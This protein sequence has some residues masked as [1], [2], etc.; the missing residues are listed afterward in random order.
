MI[1]KI[2]KMKECPECGSL[3]IIL[4]KRENELI[5][6]DCG[7]IYT[8]FVEAVPREQKPTKKIIA[9]VKKKQEKTKT[10]IFKKPVK[11]VEQKKIVKKVIVKKPLSPVK[12]TVAKKTVKKVV[13]KP[14]NKKNVHSAISSILGRFKR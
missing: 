10:K 13:A 4:N 12:K 9:A 6:K 8:E 1:S 5:C 3:D 11:K 7:L 2:S 14:V